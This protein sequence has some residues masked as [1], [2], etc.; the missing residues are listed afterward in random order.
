MDRLILM[1]A[2]ACLGLLA[3]LL[4]WGGGQDEGALENGAPRAERPQSVV[5]STRSGEVYD[6][7]VE[8]ALSRVREEWAAELARERARAAALAEEVRLLRAR[9]P[10]VGEEGADEVATVEDSDDEPPADPGDG[11]LPVARRKGGWLDEEALLEAGFHPSELEALRARFEEI[12]LERLYLRDQ[13]TREGWVGKPRFR[14]RMAVLGQRYGELRDEYGDDGYDWIL[15]ASGRTN[16]VVTGLV[17]G[18]SPA[19]HAGLEPGD[20]IYSYAGTRIFSPRALQDATK[21][22]GMPGDTVAVDVLRE[23]VE[24]RFYVPVGPL[25]VQ[26]DAAKVLPKSTR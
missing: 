2:G 1:L 16:R 8:A 15:Y 26:I 23:G 19:A 12:E 13:A 18:D 14:R 21:S 4:L 22:S 10:L 17:M 6:G 25:G 7:S 24:R 5:A 3:G 11:D 20:V 9:L